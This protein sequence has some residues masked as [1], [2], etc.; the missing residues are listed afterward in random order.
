MLAFVKNS[1]FNG[2]K[3]VS[4]A[5]INCLQTAVVSHCVK[6]TAQLLDYLRV[7]IDSHINVSLF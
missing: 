1:I 5:A 4:L 2:S 6:V 3:E 7:T